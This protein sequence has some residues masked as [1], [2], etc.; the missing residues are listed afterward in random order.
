MYIV[1]FLG[2]NSWT[3]NVYVAQI[4]RVECVNFACLGLWNSLLGQLFLI[5][6]AG[7]IVK[8][9]LSL[10]PGVYDSNPGKGKNYFVNLKPNLAFLYNKGH[11]FWKSVLTWK[12][13]KNWIKCCKERNIPKACRSIPLSICF[14]RRGL[15][16]EI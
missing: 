10:F 5:L 4:Y 11:N 15:T 13:P 9:V 6:L 2:I 3:C 1:K 7:L 8:Q 14:Y 12:I 16:E